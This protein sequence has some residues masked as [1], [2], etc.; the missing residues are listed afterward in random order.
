MHHP[1]SALIYG[2]FTRILRDYRSFNAAIL[3]AMGKTSRYLTSKIQQNVKEAHI[4]WYALCYALVVGFQVLNENSTRF[5]FH[6]IVNQLD[7]MGHK[8]AIGR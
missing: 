4:L 6:D 3:T 1:A 7:Q 5:L 2:F 8:D